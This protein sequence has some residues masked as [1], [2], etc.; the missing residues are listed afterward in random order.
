LSLDSPRVDIPIARGD[1][2]EAMSCYEAA[3]RL[4]KGDFL[5]EELY[6]PWALAKREALRTRYIEVLFSMAKLNE[7]QGAAK[8]AIVWYKK[9]VDTDPLLEEACQRLMALYAGRGMRTAAIKI[10]DQY[11]QA[12]RTELDTD[13]DPV[14]TSLYLKILESP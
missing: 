8:K 2:K 5:A 6:A 11:R 12:L 3:V 4:Y 13:P 7:A 14:T 10:Y 9:A 1:I